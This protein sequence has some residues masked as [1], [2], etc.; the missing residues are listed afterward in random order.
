MVNFLNKKNLP[1]Q[2][3]IKDLENWQEDQQKDLQD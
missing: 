1:Y 3:Q 2:D